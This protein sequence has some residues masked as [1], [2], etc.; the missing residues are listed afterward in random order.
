VCVGWCCGL[1]ER[2]R[3]AWEDKVG[4]ACVFLSLSLSLSLSETQGRT[5]VLHAT[6]A[7][8]S[9]WTRVEQNNE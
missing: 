6:K 5:R 9:T 2:G 3:N 8:E 7:V 1:A 4:K